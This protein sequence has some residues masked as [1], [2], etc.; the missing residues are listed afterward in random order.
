[1]Q[2]RPQLAV[3]GVDVGAELEQ[4]PQHLLQV[5][6]ATLWNRG[7]MALIIE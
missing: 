2:W 5:V 1:M 4:Q 3:L 6:D 7:E